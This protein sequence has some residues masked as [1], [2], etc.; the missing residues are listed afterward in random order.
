MI[1]VNLVFDRAITNLVGNRFGRATYKDQIAE[2]MTDEGVSAILPEFIEDIAS[3]FY[4]GMYAELN[5]Q[6]GTERAHELLS[7]CTKSEYTR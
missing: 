7:I 6:Y 3:S 5:E 1:V 2:K 4:E